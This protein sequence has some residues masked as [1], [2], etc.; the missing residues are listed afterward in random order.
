MAERNLYYLIYELKGIVDSL[1]EVAQYDD[2]FHHP[3]LDL[4][5]NKMNEIVQAIPKN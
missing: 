1:G 3:A 5:E 2:E 4:V